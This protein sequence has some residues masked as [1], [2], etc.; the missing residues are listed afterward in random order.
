MTSFDAV[1]AVR[2]ITR[3]KKCG[4]SG[5]LDP[6][7][8]GVLPVFIGGATRFIELLSVHDKTYTAGFR[9]GAVTDTL[10]IT[11]KVMKEREVAVGYN[12]VCALLPEF[13]GKILQTPP[14][15][16]AISKNGVRLYELARKGIEIER[17]ARE[18]TIH[19]LSITSFNEA[20][21]EYTID[22]SCS[23]GT[24]IRS[25]ISDIGERLGCGAVMTSLRR[26]SSNGFS[27]SD[28]L[29][30]GQLSEAFSRGDLSFVRGVDAVLSDYPEITVT[31][32]QAVRFFNGGELDITRLRL[33]C[34]GVFY[35]MYSPEGAFLG[36]GEKSGGQMLVK[37]VFNNV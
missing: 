3:E 4:H 18:I 26:T 1:A 7:A 27:L 20:A 13:T 24:Y 25:L 9:L 19:S 23:A 32:P 31:Q 14:M 12:E 28:A 5:T 29:T 36:I 15:Y 10:D 11:G 8:T 22:V 6:M 35:R 33:P 30:P 37:R 17:E 2:R 16:S 34:E 21:G